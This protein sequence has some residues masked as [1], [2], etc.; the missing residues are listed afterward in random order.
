M[1]KQHRILVIND[2]HVGSI[3]GLSPRV[4]E[5]EKGPARLPDGEQLAL[6][7]NWLKFQRK[8]SRR[9]TDTVVFLGDMVDGPGYKARGRE[10]MSPDTGDQVRNA[11]SLLEPFLEKVDPSSVYMFSG[12][13]Y[14]SNNQQ[15]NEHD[16]ADLLGVEYVGVGPH[17]FEFNDI[18]INFSHGGGGAYWYRGTKMD[19]TLFALQLCKADSGLYNASHVIRGHFH[20]AAWLEYPPNQHIAVSPCWQLQTDYMRKKDAFKMVPSIGSLELTVK[21]GKVD[22][23]FY[24]YLHPPRM[25][26][27]PKGVKTTPESWPRFDAGGLKK[28]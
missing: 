2:L 23:R 11:A 16:L 17:D 26:L 22:H 12:T 1:I 3:W 19:K 10:Q 20:F 25:K 15:T 21:G 13:D 8:I 28:R 7:K 5:T 4:F 24:L 18:T 14:H 27:K 9:K 6:L